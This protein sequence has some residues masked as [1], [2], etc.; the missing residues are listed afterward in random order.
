MRGRNPQGMTIEELRGHI[1]RLGG[2]HHLAQGIGRSV[3]SVRAWVRGK[4]NIHPRVAILI[5]ALPDGP[6][7]ALTHSEFQWA[8]HERGGSDAVARRYFFPHSDV[9]RWL[10]GDTVPPDGLLQ[11][12]RD[13]CFVTVS[14]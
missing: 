8:V 13:A 4:S 6:K 12:L 5:R 2:E 9:L 1:W 11:E 3:F 7:P 10:R 14:R